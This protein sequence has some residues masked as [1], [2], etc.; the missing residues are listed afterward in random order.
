M[1][2][3]PMVYH[4]TTPL[5]THGIARAFAQT[6][7]RGDVVAFLGGMGVGKTA[8]VAGIGQ[9]LA[10]GGEISSPTFALVHEYPAPPE[11]P[12]APTLVH[13]DLYRLQTVEDLDSIG[14]FDYLEGD[15]IPAG[16]IVLIEWSERASDW[17]P[18]HTIFVEISVTGEQSRRI[19]ITRER[20]KQD[21]TTGD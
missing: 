4:A 12:G 15:G 8:F 1:K 10:P 19:T 17:L 5:E 20:E 21:A 13:M 18:A 7:R 14:F 11:R 16:Y 9:A 2:C 3:N 6:L